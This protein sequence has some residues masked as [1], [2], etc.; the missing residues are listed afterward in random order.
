MEIVDFLRAAI[1][2]LVIVLGYFRFLIRRRRSRSWPAAQ[3]LYSLAESNRILWL[4]IVIA[5][6]LVMPSKQT[7]HATLVFLC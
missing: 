5:V 1:E 2:V 6:S 4:R 3:V 7:G